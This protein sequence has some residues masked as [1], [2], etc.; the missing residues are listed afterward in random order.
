MGFASCCKSLLLL[1]VSGGL[2]YG[3]VSAPH[4]ISVQPL[5]DL[6]AR[7]GAEA[8]VALQ[9]TIRSGYHI[10]SEAPADEYLIPTALTW[11]PGPLALKAVKYPK[12]ESVRYSFSDKPMLVFS[13]TIRLDSRFAVGATT[14]KGLVTLSGKLRYQA[15][16]EKMCLPPRTLDVS[17]PL[18]VE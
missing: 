14:P 13:G 16:N 3:Q 4:L 9:V 10:N 12:A 7:R 2:L 6:V 1:A 17:V 5:P 11:T 8:D 15:C 18:R